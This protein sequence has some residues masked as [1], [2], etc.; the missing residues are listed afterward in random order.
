MRIDRFIRD[1][2]RMQ[3]RSSRRVPTKMKTSTSGLTFNYSIVESIACIHMRRGGFILGT[4][5]EEKQRWFDLLDEL[6]KSTDINAVLLFNEPDAL[7]EDEHSAYLELL[8]ELRDA[9]R[10]ERAERLL[11]REENAFDQ[12]ANKAMGYDKLLVSC[13]TGDIAT[14]FFGLSLVSDVRLAQEGM[15]FCLSHADHGIP[16]VG[17]L[18]YLL[19]KYVGQGR[20]VHWLLSGGHIEAQAALESGLVNSILDAGTFEAECINWVKKFLERG[21]A[22]VQATRRL[23]YHEKS[24]FAHYLQKENKLRLQASN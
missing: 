18:G 3:F 12:Y 5:L 2:C 6:E 19:P 23:V 10:G 9:E 22:H 13:L 4:D 11:A 24:I 21:D 20:A 15:R 8:L 1:N 17:G 14:P 16:P 7:T